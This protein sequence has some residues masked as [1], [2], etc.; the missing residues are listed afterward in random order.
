M[1]KTILLLL[2]VSSLSNCSKQNKNAQKSGNEN[3]KTENI[4]AVQKTNEEIR[5]DNTYYLN[6]PGNMW[7]Q[8]YYGDTENRESISDLHKSKVVVLEEIDGWKKIFFLKHPGFG[9]F[10]FENKYF[11]KSLYEI[12]PDYSFMKKVVGKYYYDRIEIEKNDKKKEIT[13]RYEGNVITLDY[14][15]GEEFL[16]TEVNFIGDE[17]SFRS[18]Y[19]CIVPNNNIDPFLVTYASGVKGTVNYEYYFIDEG[20]KIRTMPKYSGLIY[21]V[22]YFKK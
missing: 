21:D 9:P 4:Q 2:L 19:E 7:L 11:V 15:E 16:I 13:Y 17:I 10:W 3:N 5:D 20:I 18:Q 1:K 8:R 22:I 12:V 14:K 6:I